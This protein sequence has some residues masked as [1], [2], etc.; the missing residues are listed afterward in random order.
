MVRLLFALWLICVGA[1]ASAQTIPPPVL[2]I[3]RVSLYQSSRYALQLRQDIVEKYQNQSAETR[4]LE[5]TLRA[6]EL[7]L[8]ELRKTMSP[9]DFAVAAQKFDDRAEAAR[10]NAEENQRAADT[11]LAQQERAFFLRVR[12]IIGQIMVERGA[13]LVLE[14]SAAIFMKFNILDITDVAR[15]RIDAELAA[16]IE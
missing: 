4:R 6:E 8:T 3:D 13:T 9:E 14:D 15:D 16:P 10:R 12:P 5:H 7:K 2:V 11:E 1:F